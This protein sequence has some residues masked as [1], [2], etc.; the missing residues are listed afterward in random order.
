MC[1]VRDLPRVRYG[2]VWWRVGNVNECRCVS[3]LT[4]SRSVAADRKFCLKVCLIYKSSVFFPF[5][6]FIC[7][8]FLFFSCSFDSVQVNDHCLFN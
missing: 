4:D 8:I 5:F 1:V 2:D 3:G 6:I 7:F